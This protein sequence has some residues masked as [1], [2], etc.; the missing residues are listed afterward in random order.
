MKGV[1]KV[2]KFRVEFVALDA[3]DEITDTVLFAQDVEAVNK[4]RA[5]D[6]AV[7][8]F[9]NQLPEV[10]R[11]YRHNYFVHVKEAQ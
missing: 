3:T 4:I 8:A 10:Y 11:E 2:K 5:T 7:K 1:L 6:E 9:K